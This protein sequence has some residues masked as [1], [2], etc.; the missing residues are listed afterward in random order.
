MSRSRHW[1][2]RA[3]RSLAAH[4]DR[5]RETLSRLNG[6][7]REAVAGAVGGG[8]AAA[9]EDAVRA[10]LTEPAA[11]P[12]D[13]PDYPSPSRVWGGADYR[14]PPSWAAHDQQTYDPYDEDRRYDEEPRPHEPDEPG[15]TASAA[16]SRAGRW[17]LALT[18]GLQ[19]AAWW[20]HGRPGRVAA[21]A[22]LGVGAAAA[23]AA[24]LAG[25]LLAAGAGL[26]GSALTLAAL[27]DAARRGA[28]LFRP[29]AA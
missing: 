12:M 21:L 25:P 29:G 2:A 10:L 23:L 4:L 26:A 13:G 6:R 15:G 17:G 8:A 5:L 16:G 9:V 27:C 3:A 20:L 18:A 11:P 14:D 28:A 22:A 1:A 19:A 24:Y 7:L